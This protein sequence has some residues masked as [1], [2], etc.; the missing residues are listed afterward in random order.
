VRALYSLLCTIFSSSATA[1][2]ATKINKQI[3]Q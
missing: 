1:V 3:N 2:V